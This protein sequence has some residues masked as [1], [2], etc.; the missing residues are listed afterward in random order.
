MEDLAIVR[1]SIFIIFPSQTF[2]LLN[3]QYQAGLNPYEDAT[4]PFRSSFNEEGL[5]K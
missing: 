3:A 1:S 2:W 5:N 4:Q